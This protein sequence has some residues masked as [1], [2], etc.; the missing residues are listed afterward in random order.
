MNGFAVTKLKTDTQDWLGDSMMNPA[1]QSE[2]QKSIIEF[3]VEAFTDY[4]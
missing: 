4:R 2:L 1:F 3:C